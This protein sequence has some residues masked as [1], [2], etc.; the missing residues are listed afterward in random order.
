[1]DFTPYAAWQRALEDAFF[2]PDWDGHPVVMYVDDGEAEQLRERFSLATPLAEAVRGVVLPGEPRAYRAVE[3]YEAS[4]HDSV[5]PCGRAALAC[6][7]SDRSHP[8]GPRW[9]PKSK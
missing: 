1:M 9:E 7:F 2:S 3:R 6:M 8:H 5:D 4:K